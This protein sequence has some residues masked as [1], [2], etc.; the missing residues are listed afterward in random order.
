MSCGGWFTWKWAAMGVAGV[1]MGLGAAVTGDLDLKVPEDPVEAHRLADG[2]LLPRLA[3]DLN[4]FVI[5]HGRM[6]EVGHFG[7]HRAQDDEA[8]VAVVKAFG[9]W[10]KGMERAGYQTK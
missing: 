10:K 6:E 2:V 9:E 8:V 1:G 4:V 5:G 7:Q 3:A